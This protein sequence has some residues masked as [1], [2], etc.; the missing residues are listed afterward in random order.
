MPVFIYNQSF[1]FYKIGYGA[2]LS[3]VMMLLVGGISAMYFWL[4]RKVERLR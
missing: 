3:F 2:A 1:R 4:L